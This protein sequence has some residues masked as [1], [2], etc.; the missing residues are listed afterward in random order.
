[1]AKWRLV[2]DHYLNVSADQYGEKIDYEYAETDA[3]TNRIRRRSWAVP[4]F[5]PR[6][7][8]VTNKQED[9][10]AYNGDVNHR[11]IV[12]LGDP[13]PD[14]MPVDEEATKISATF[15]AKWKHAI[16][17]LSGTMGGGD[18]SASLIAGLEKMMDQAAVR[19]GQASAVVPNVSTAGV[20]PAAFAQMQKQM[21][22]LMDLNM[23]LL[24]EKAEA[25]APV[26][27]AVTQ[28]KAPAAAERRV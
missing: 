12:F 24:A 18:F 14:M 20:D 9:F 4:M 26:P 28:P 25:T 11:P 15:Q 5:I 27:A 16:E 2:H 10:D 17:S 7:S 21:Q 19:N 1:M 22:E 23:K 3:Q 13:T 8:I 6:D